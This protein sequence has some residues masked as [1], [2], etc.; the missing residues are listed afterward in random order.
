VWFQKIPIPPPQRVIGNSEGEGILK[1][2]YFK[3]MYEPKLEFPEGWG[4]QTKQTLCGGS[5][6][7][8]WNNIFEVNEET[9]MVSHCLG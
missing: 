7:I 2:K 8:F 3:R 1:A 6:D 9:K 5:R 4:V